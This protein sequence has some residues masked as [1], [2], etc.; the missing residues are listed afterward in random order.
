[1]YS[2]F[3]PVIYR[4][5]F[6]DINIS[7]S[8]L[9]GEV[10]SIR[11]RLCLFLLRQCADMRRQ[12]K[13]TYLLVPNSGPTH[14]SWPRPEPRLNLRADADAEVRDRG[15]HHR[16]PHSETDTGDPVGKS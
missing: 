13:L 5:A 3:I 12:Y 15:I 8:R 6:C 7:R 9:Q 4:S 11:L 14:P 16:R 1:M 2:V 10:R